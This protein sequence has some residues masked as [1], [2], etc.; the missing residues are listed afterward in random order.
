MYKVV[1]EKVI[2]SIYDLDDCSPNHIYIRGH[3]GHLQVL[4]KYDN[5]GQSWGWYSLKK[6][7]LFDHDS[8]AYVAYVSWRAALEC[9]LDERDPIWGF[10]DLAELGKFLK[11]EGYECN[12]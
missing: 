5:V 11:K 1:K 4:H 8:C 2:H 7:Y 9:A 12:R 6:G 10:D 3:D